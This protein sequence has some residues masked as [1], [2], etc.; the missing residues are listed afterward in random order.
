M[1]QEMQ[2]RKCRKEFRN[3]ELFDN[4]QICLSFFFF[5]HRQ[6]KSIEYEPYNSELY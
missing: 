2:E 5:H 4:F 6:L 1:D 3:A